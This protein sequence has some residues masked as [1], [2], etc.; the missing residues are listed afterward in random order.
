MAKIIIYDTD[1]IEKDISNFLKNYV[2]LM[3]CN[4]YISEGKQDEVFHQYRETY[5]AI[6]GLLDLSELKEK[7]N[8]SASWIDFFLEKMK[9]FSQEIS[10]H[11]EWYM[12]K[13]LSISKLYLDAI[14]KSVDPC[15]VLDEEQRKVVL[16]DSDASLVVAGAGAGKTTT[17]AAKVK[18]LVE[19]RKVNPEE[20]IVISY[21]RKAVKELSDKI[22]KQLGIEA[23]VTTFHA[24]GN[25]IIRNTTEDY[26]EVETYKRKYFIDILKNR[27][28]QNRILLKN[29]ILFLGYYMDI[30]EEA[31]KFQTLSQ[32]QAYKASVDLESMRSTLNQYTKKVTDSLTKQVRTIKGEFL[33]SVQEVQI[34]NFLYLHGLDYEY[35]KVYEFDILSAKKK[36]TPDF[37]IKQG[38]REVYLEHF[39]INENGTSD[40]FSQEELDKYKK[41]AADKIVIHKRYHTEIIWTYSNYNDGRGLLQHL[42]SLLIQ[43]GFDLTVRDDKEVYR[44]LMQVENDKYVYRLAIFM[45]T[46]ISRFK[47]NG[48]D[49]TDFQRL[50][51]KTD[52][53][54]NRLFLDIAEEVYKQY[55][56]MLIQNRKI[57]FED[58][59]NQ[60]EKTLAQYDPTKV[61][62]NYKYVIIDEYQDIARQRFQLTKRLAD[63]CHAKIIAVGDD[64]QSIY[65]FSGSDITLFT[66]FIELMGHGEMLKIT[67]TYRNSQELIDVA[68]NFIQENDSQIKKQLKSP[69]HIE[70]PIVIKVYDDSYDIM[71]HK[72]EAL[73]AVLEQIR[74]EFGDE[75][76]VLFIGRY[77]FDLNQICKT[78]E[79]SQD[80]QKSRS[81][82]KCK[83]FPKMR[84]TYLTAHSS[85]GLGYD[86][87]IVLNGMEGKFG[88]PSQIEDDPILKLVTVDDNTLPFAE[89]RRLFYVALTRTKNRTYIL[90]PENRPSRFVMELVEKY[91]LSVERELKYHAVSSS[92]ITVH[93]PICGYPLKKEFNQN[94]GLTLY[95]CTNEPEVCDFMTNRMDCLKD[96]YKCERCEKGYMIIKPNTKTGQYFFGCTNY[97]TQ[98]IHCKNT[99]T[100]ESE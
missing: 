30:P 68:G 71:K 6:K 46:F 37:Y 11:N 25:E 100:I 1:G 50:R 58:M 81:K 86:N 9:C 93:C 45:E 32:Y 34:A 79:F 99:V 49:E 33:R 13:Q 8:I 12:N 92:G 80:I 35:E 31:F 75:A 48:Y 65:A 85:K 16:N 3:F 82:V 36:Y 27:I 14:L 55:Q 24:F 54:R 72:T 43:K 4:E 51:K 57:D 69:K 56:A 23:K 62:L 88:F 53:V 42:E 77:G 83:R 22:N 47:T 95:M 97:N 44:Q 63:I 21:T 59:I 18:Y 15:I 87:V 28:F 76:E 20:I 98:G 96:I 26:P 66:Q 29:M 52:N 73:L 19:K 78:G 2:D 90:T 61:P 84:L 60:A 64:W 17:V 89:E 70:N 38:T 39:G 74:L 10:I 40:R 94:Y 7:L 41:S 5:E 67:K 91:H